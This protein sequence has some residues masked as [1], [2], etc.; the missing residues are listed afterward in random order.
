METAVPFVAPGP[1][2]FDERYVWIGY[3][4]RGVELGVGAVHYADCLMVIHVMPSALRG[5]A[6]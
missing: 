1:S 4:D 6:R 5:G 3:D 2:G